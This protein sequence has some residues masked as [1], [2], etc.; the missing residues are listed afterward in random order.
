MTE[1]ISTRT[2]PRRRRLAGLAA[3]ALP[4]ALVLGGCGDDGDDTATDP[5]ASGSLSSGT[6]SSATPTETGPASP[7]VTD[8]ATDSA[9]ESADPVPELPQVVVDG[10][11]PA[12]ETGFPALIPSGLPDGWTVE[13][14]QF[15]ADH[16]LWT[17]TLT[18]DTGA[19]VTL[20]QVDRP[21][22]E[23]ATQYAGTAKAGGKV[24]LGPLGSWDT[25]SGSDEAIGT[26]LPTT[27]VVVYGSDQAHLEALGQTLAAAEDSDIPDAG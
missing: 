12:L 25:Y 11:K 2:S 26:T 7:T 27:S 15:Q 13:D 16:E 6:S 8:S 20:V 4:A 17:M 9:T 5:G 21:L 19:T 18:D 24:D 23:L 3:F 14:A 10:V 1:L 22:S